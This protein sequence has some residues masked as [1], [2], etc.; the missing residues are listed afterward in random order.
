[1]FVIRKVTLAT[2]PLNVDEINQALAAAG[3]SDVTM[4]PEWNGAALTVEG[5]PVIVA[6][7]QEAGI[8]LMQTAPL[9]MTTPPEFRFD[10]FMEVAF[11]VFGRSTTEARDLA[12]RLAANPA[13]LMVLRPG[14]HAVA[15]EIASQAGPVSIIGSTEGGMCAFWSAPGRMFIVSAMKMDEKLAEAIASSVAAQGAVEY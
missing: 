9:K 14:H 3:I 4:R 2:E 6:R 5:G 8:E 12:Q 1:M 11:R 13:L 10:Q 7:Y 15:R